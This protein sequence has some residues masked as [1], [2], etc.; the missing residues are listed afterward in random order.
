MSAGPP[1]IAT[2]SSPNGLDVT[3]PKRRR[4]GSE[5]SDALSDGGDVR[6]KKRDG[7]GEGDTEQVRPFLRL[8]QIVKRFG[9][10]TALKTIDLDIREGEFVCFLG[11][12]GCGKSTLLR[13]IAGL[14][15][16]TSGNL[17]ETGRDISK[18]STAERRFGILFQSYALFPN[19]TVYEN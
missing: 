6:M 3:S 19:L 12:S 10:F 13:I 5:A 18:M 17:L 2:G 7:N 4:K 9:G 1:T 11:P 16:Q 15:S 8:E 14:E